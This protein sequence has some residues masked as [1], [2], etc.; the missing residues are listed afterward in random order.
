MSQVTESLAKMREKEETEDLA[1]KVTKLN[2]DLDSKISEAE[3]KLTVLNETFESFQT[4]TKENHTTSSSK[5]EEVEAAIRKF[6]SQSSETVGDVMSD[7]ENL[8]VRVTDKNITMLQKFSKC[9][10]M[11]AWCGNLAICLPLRLFMKSILAHF[12]V[13]KTAISTIFEALNYVF[14]EF[15]QFTGSRFTKIQSLGSL[16]LSKWRFLRLKSCQY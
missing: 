12:R 11:A 15:V 7:T 10:V 14:C 3:S 16:K 4:L 5:L 2:E 8:K 13:S 1:T 6:K 9:E